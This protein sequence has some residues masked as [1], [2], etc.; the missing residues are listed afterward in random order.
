M[1]GACLGPAAVVALFQR[2][3]MSIEEARDATES[4][5][6]TSEAQGS[7]LEVQ[8]LQLGVV[9]CALRNARSAAPSAPNSEPGGAVGKGKGKARADAAVV[10]CGKRADAP[11]CAATAS[12]EAL[13]TIPLLSH[14]GGGGGT[15]ITRAHRTARSR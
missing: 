13:H 2:H 8:Q 5:A 3:G 4:F 11:R 15:L 12:V 14:Y 9:S 7:V 1:R 6:K 10:E